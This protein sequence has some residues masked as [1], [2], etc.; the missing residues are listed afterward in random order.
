MDHREVFDAIRLVFHCDVPDALLREVIEKAIK[1]HRQEAGSRRDE[2]ELERES[3]SEKE[4]GGH[5]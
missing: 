3:K 1:D 2:M 4:A 5:V